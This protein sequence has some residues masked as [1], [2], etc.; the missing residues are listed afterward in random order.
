MALI[1]S[2]LA[3]NFV[4]AGYFP[5]DEVTLERIGQM[6]RLAP[7]GNVRMLD[8]CCGEGTALADTRCK[9][10]YAPKGA[11]QFLID[12]QASEEG[13]AILPES[14][15]EAPYAVPAA[16]ADQELD[17]HA[18]RIDEAQ[19]RDELAKYRHMTTRATVHQIEGNCRRHMFS[20]GGIRGDFSAQVACTFPGRVTA[21][22]VRAQ[23][24]QCL[25]Q[26]QEILLAVQKHYEAQAAAHA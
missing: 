1:F 26:L 5:T 16:Q 20:F 14:W 11:Q 23:H 7:A 6:L 15:E 22:V 13:A 17:F 19:L 24:E 9:P 4:K 21:N 18:V 8:P 10:A 2:R 3:H 12:A 25:G